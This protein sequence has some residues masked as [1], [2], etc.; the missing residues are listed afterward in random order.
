MHLQNY[1]LTPAPLR[2]KLLRNFLLRVRSNKQSNQSLNSCKI[3]QNCVFVVVIIGLYVPKPGSNLGYGRQNGVRIGLFTLKLDL[4]RVFRYM[5]FS[6]YGLFGRR[7]FRYRGF[8][9]YG[10]FGSH[11]NTMGCLVEFYKSLSL[12]YTKNVCVQNP[13][14]FPTQVSLSP[15]Q[16][17]LVSKIGTLPTTPLIFKYT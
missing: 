10:L 11:P 6:L 16:S 9:V 14:I 7:A 15:E 1:K 5:G 3:H 8:W 2:R 13:T 4:W 12:Y 17:T